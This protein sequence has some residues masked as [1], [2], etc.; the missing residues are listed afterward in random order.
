MKQ[1]SLDWEI[2]GFAQE[3]RNNSVHGYVEVP[4]NRMDAL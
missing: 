4:A 1:N 3:T 2:R